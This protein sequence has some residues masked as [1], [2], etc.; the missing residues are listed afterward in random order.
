MVYPSPGAP[1]GDTRLDGST[2]GDTV[3]FQLTC[4]AGDEY[5]LDPVLDAVKARFDDWRP[6]LPDPY[7]GQPIGRSRLLNDPGPSRRDDNES[8]PRFW[9][10]LIYSNTLNT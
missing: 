10:P 4:V 1:S 7:D 2:A 5:A 9:V 6:V 3:T 8:P